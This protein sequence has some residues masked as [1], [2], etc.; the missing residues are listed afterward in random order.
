MT[1]HTEEQ[2]DDALGAALRELEV[3]EHRPEFHEA[4][5]A[6]LEREAADRGGA[7][8]E[9]RPVRPH[10][11]RRG[12]PHPR[13]RWAWGL[14]TAAAIS[15]LAVVAVMVGVPGRGPGVATAAEVRARVAQAWATADSVS[16]VLAIEAVDP[17]REVRGEGPSSLRRWSFLLT[18][19]GDFRLTSIDGPDDVAYDAG[20]NVER[21]LNTSASIPDSDVLFASEITGLAPGPPDPAPSRE[22]LDRGLGSVVRALVA[23]GGGR[24]RE[25][26]YGGWE[27][28]LL[29]TDVPAA[30]ELSPD[31]LRVTVNRETG[32][33]VRVVAFRDGRRVS[34]TRIQDLRVNPPLPAGA[35]SLEFPEGMD[36]SRTD[37]GFRPVR[38]EDV[39]SA[40]GY[41]PLVPARIPDGYRLAEVM[42]SEKPTRTGAF[43]GNPPVGDIV[44]LSY[45]RGLDQF[46][47]TIRPVGEEPGAWGDPF[48]RGE[49]S[50]GEPERVTFSAGALAGGQGELVVDP[51]TP[52]HVWA[53]T[54]RFVVTVSG[55]LTRPE[56]LQVAES[57]D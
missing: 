45:R 41:E 17:A 27:A 26:T 20:T 57:L 29:E 53:T 9:P 36:V 8:R 30:V 34:E 18:A 25:V 22:I 38:L 48:D 51:M 21:G 5:W 54:D 44:S 10:P 56:L 14:A 32:F 1:G 15:A 52:P 33:P 4:V 12:R 49:G 50:L 40:V 28:W 42:V 37:Y 43:G 2:R 24:V 6:M 35:F 47:V 13:R 3:P 31:H 55:D 46:I 39:A 11:P 23:G 7:R 19:Q 16:G